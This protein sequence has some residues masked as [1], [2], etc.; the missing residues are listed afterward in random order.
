MI[1]DFEP[2][3]MNPQELPVILSNKGEPELPPMVEALWQMAGIR[4]AEVL[5]SLT[6]VS[7][8]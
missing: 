5:D 8:P 4:N 3:E 7:T 2:L 6:D 1:E